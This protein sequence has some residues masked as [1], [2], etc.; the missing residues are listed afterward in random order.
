LTG[1]FFSTIL[2]LSGET[3]VNE[4]AW[5]EQLAESREKATALFRKLEEVRGFL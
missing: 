4:T 3:E 2:P 5:L 1:G